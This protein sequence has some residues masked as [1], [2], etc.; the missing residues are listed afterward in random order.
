[1]GLS[2]NHPRV[3]EESM[4]NKGAQKLIPLAISALLMVPQTSAFADFKKVGRTTAT[5]TI[6]TILNGKGAPS[7]SL[8]IKIGR[9]HV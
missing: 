8:G 7:A 1:M 2:P 3:K 4:F 6:N 9:A 5:G